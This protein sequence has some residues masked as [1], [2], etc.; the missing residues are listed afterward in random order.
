MKENLVFV[1]FGHGIGDT[2][3]PDCPFFIRMGAHLK[4]QFSPIDNIVMG[5]KISVQGSF[6]ERSRLDINV[7]SG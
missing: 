3:G 4:N 6:I 2:V 1:A 5:D 7:S